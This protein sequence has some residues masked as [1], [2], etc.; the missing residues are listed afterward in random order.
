MVGSLYQNGKEMFLRQVFT[1]RSSLAYFSIANRQIPPPG[2]PQLR[3]TWENSPKSEL[4][5]ALT[6]TL[7]VRIGQK[8]CCA[9]KQLQ[10]LCGI[11]Q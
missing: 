5:L 10:N 1:N 8:F 9:N 7:L 2:T 3:V 4:R 6:T 11:T